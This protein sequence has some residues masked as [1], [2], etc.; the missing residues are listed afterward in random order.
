[1][2]DATIQ[3]GVLEEHEKQALLK[4]ALLEGA[5]IA[6]FDIYINSKL[7]KRAMEIKALAPEKSKQAEKRMSN[8]CP[9][10][11][12]PIPPLSKTCPDCGAAVVSSSTGD[13]EL[14]SLI[15]AL[16]RSLIRLKTASRL[17]FKKEKAEVES[18][19][20]KAKLFYGD[21]KKVQMM[22]SDLEGKI[23]E[24]T[25]AHRIKSLISNIVYYAIMIF[26]GFITI[27]T[28]WVGF[29]V[30][31]LALMILYYMFHNDKFLFAK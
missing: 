2:V 26:L 12:S 13:E 17:G 15:D 3:D 5:D 6:E 23:E 9:H 29:G 28:I 22:V 21:N 14:F 18:Y 27:C 8:R 31:S 16:E 19:I 20:R 4:R 30:I 11:G 10:C 7:Q 24:L 25:K 1:M